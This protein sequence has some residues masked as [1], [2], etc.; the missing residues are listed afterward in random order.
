LPTDQHFFAKTSFSCLGDTSIEKSL[1]A[2][3]ADQWVLIGCETHVCVLQTARALH[4]LGK[5]VVV[6]SDAVSSR[7]KHNY[8][9]ALAEMRDEGIR[10]ASTETIA[11][12]LMHDSKDPLFK[13]MSLIFR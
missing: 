3:S 12:E 8:E 7:T 5:E 13:A 4:S 6:V 9:V 11:F 10:I 1:L 2:H